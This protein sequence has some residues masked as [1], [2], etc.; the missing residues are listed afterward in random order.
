MSDL[1]SDRESDAGQ[2]G[3]KSPQDDKSSREASHEPDLFDRAFGWQDEDNAQEHV[4][5]LTGGPME[6]GSGVDWKD[7][8][9]TLF[10]EHVPDGQTSRYTHVLRDMLSEEHLT[11]LRAMY[12]NH[13]DEGIAKF[14]KKRQN[15]YDLVM[16]H[17]SAREDV[18]LLETLLKD[19]QD[20]CKQL[21]DK[22]HA[23]TKELENSQ[24]EVEKCD[25]LVIKMAAG[26]RTL[27]EAQKEIRKLASAKTG[28]SEQDKAEIN[29]RLP[30]P[31]TMAGAAQALY[32]VQKKLEQGAAAVGNKRPVEAVGGCD[33]GRG[34]RGGRGGRVGK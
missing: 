13:D 31:P 19:E 29:A 26:M 17:L 1:G 6:A 32:D 2:Y 18:H 8:M 34:G 3:G 20:K 33:S 9:E 7:F 11:R 10:D 24:A 30:G 15:L 5:G 16:Y 14:F 21:E 23:K 27:H 25:H 22:L 4:G 28:L 12:Q